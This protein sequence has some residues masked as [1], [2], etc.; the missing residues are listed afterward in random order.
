METQPGRRKQGPDPMQWEGER[1][2]GAGLGTQ[3]TKCLWAGEGGVGRLRKRMSQFGQAE[4]EV[5]V[6][7]QIEKPQDG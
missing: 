5:P 2:E 1:R 6:G 7:N 3:R 4:L